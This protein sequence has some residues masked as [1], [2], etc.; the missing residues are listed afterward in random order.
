MHNRIIKTMAFAPYQA[1]DVRQYFD[2]FEIHNLEQINILEIGKFMYK[3]KNNLLPERFNDYFQVSGTMHR[4]N[5]R[6]VANQNYEQHRAKGLYGLKMI[7]HT[8]VKL[9]NGFPSEIKNQST[10]K[11]FTNLF[12][13][14]VLE[15][16]N[17][18]HHFK[19]LPFTKILW[20]NWARGRGGWGWGEVSKAIL[21]GWNKGTTYVEKEW[22]DSL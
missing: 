14:Y 8:G 21:Q 12:K 16:V 20:P 11:K 5:L 22:R 4:Y 17:L 3:Y 1:T 15:M 7:H 13:F 6:S 9:W 10:L 2:K 18:W 19:K